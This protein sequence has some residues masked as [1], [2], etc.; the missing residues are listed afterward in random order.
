MGT[1]TNVLRVGASLLPLSPA[2]LLIRKQLAKMM[3]ERC[4]ELFN[5]P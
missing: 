2:Y 4:F 5:I 1:G 3:L